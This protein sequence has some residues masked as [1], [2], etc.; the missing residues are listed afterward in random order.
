MNG[1]TD[2]CHKA[3]A[4]QS[5]T[6][7]SHHS[8]YMHRVAF[9]DFLRFLMYSRTKKISLYSS[10]GESCASTSCLI[11]AA[12][13]L[14]ALSDF[15]DIICFC[16]WLT[17]ISAH[18]GQNIASFTTGRDVFYIL[19]TYSLV[20]I[21]FCSVWSM[22]TVLEWIRSNLMLQMDCITVIHIV[23]ECS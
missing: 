23:H 22:N 2:I 20:F 21:S 13:V 15:S 7:Q 12:F 3:P 4:L 10:A 1:L 11:M 6:W 8:T 17:Q 5:Y 19:S 16:V 14:I 9:S 18:S